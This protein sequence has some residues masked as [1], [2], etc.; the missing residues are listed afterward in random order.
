MSHSL[1]L[2]PNSSYQDLRSLFITTAQNSDFQVKIRKNSLFISPRSTKESF[3]FFDAENGLKVLN[4]DIEDRK[5]VTNWQ[6]IINSY[7]ANSLRQE[8]T[9]K[10][11]EIQ[12]DFNFKKSRLLNTNY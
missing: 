7:L 10:V 1:L 6:T 11:E 12:I 4:E 2:V 5:L 3:Y 9:L 8:Q